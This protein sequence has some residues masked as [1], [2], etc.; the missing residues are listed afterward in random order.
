MS[1]SATYIARTRFQTLSEDGNV[2]YTTYG[3]RIYD[4]YDSAYVN[5]LDTLEELIAMD[6]DELIE[7]IRDNCTAAS[8][9]IDTAKYCE[10]PLYVDDELHSG[11]EEDDED[12]AADIADRMALG[13][14][15][16]GVLASGNDATSTSGR[17][18]DQPSETRADGA[19]SRAEAGS[20]NLIEC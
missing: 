13:A 4:D 10:L 6:A 2:M 11:D 15:N 20:L 7:H 16:F 5:Q 1:S 19:S 9:I 18:T 17:Q 12:L 8:A 3:A 14:G